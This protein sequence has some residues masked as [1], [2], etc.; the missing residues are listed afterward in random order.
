MPSF[1]VFLASSTEQLTVASDIA[2]ALS[3]LGCRPI[4]WWTAFG[5]S[6]YTLESLEASL[7]QS[8]AAVF[9]CAGDDTGSIRGISASF[10][11]DNVILELGFFLSVLGRRRCFIVADD[12][13]TLRLPSDLA[14]VTLLSTAR[15]PDSIASIVTNSIVDSFK[16]E[17]RPSP[18]GCIHIRA[19]SEITSRVAVDIPAGWHQRA[20]YYGTEGAKAWLAYSDDE[21]TNIQTSADQISDEEQ[22]IAALA[23]QSF[24]TVVSLGPGDARRDKVIHERLQ[25]DNAGLQYVPVDISEGL[26]HY[27]VRTLSSAG[28]AVPF[29]ILADFEEGQDFVFENIKFLP[30]P[31]LFT[32][33]GNTLGN[34]DIGSERFLRKLAT[35]MRRGD[36]LLVDVATTNEPWNFDPYRR[37]FAS[38][39]R[40]HFIAQGIARQLGKPTHE[41]LDHF[42]KRIAAKRADRAP[43]HAE[44]QVI[45]D[46]ETGKLG[47]TLRAYYFEK[48]RDWVREQVGLKEE[49][50]T[51]YFFEGVAFGAGLIRLSKQ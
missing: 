21:Y 8:D 40:R 1:T 32:L 15:D 36:Q 13:G 51:E 48:L 38:P 45:F 24:R 35:R 46:K 20:L 47:L 44:Q 4:R 43:A 42:E 5:P 23:G 30:R 2:N 33:L 14:G 10:P 37:Y 26:L 49:Y 17:P 29:G 39:V 50:T 9:L 7:R 27:A 41:I 31:C 18:N 34:L 16:S 12:N 11:R 19:D 25:M 6:T 3:N 22:T 28:A